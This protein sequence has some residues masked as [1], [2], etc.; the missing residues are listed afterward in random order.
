MVSL[1]HHYD[2]VQYVAQ[3]AGSEQALTD[4]VV[5]RQ[6]VG[7]PVDR[8][9]ILRKASEVRPVV[10]SD[11]VDL[12]NTLAKPAIEEKLHPFQ[13]YDMD[14]TAFMTRSKS[15]KVIAV[16]GSSDMWDTETTMNF[17]L[18]IAACASATGHVVLPLF[19]L[20]GKRW[21]SPF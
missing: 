5:E 12:F 9:A 7:R 11:I 2:S 19:N 4:W 8:Q 18:T 6:R 14:E 15:K 13:V 20:P 17:H 1:Q 3:E 10:N 16:R 21:V